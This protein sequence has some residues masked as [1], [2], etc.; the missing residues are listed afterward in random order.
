MPNSR[1]Q[2]AHPSTIPQLEWMERHSLTRWYAHL[3]RC[4]F[5]VN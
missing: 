4:A 2:T 3:Y 1:V 5:H